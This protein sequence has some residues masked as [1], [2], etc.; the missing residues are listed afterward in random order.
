MSQ[1]P[2]WDPPDPQTRV[3]PT[4]GRRTVRRATSRGQRTRSVPRALGCAV[5]S[6]L[7]PGL[8]Q[9]VQRR[10][11]TAALFGI[12]TVAVLVAAVW[13]VG[14]DKVTLVDWTVDSS[15]PARRSASPVC[16]GP[17]SATR[18]PRT[19][20][21]PRGRHASATAPAPPAT[22]LVVC[23]AVAALLPGTAFALVTVRQD[24]LLDTVFAGSGEVQVAR[25]S[26]LADLGITTTRALRRRRPSPSPLRRRPRPR[27]RPSRRRPS[28]TT[29]PTTP[30][31][32]P[33]ALEHR[34]ARRRRRTQPL[35]PAHRHDDR[36]QRRPPDGRPG[37]RLGAPQPHAAPDAGRAAAATAS[38]T[39]STTWPTRST[40][41]SPSTPSS[42]STRRRPSRAPWPSCSASRSTTT[43]SS[44]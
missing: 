28:P 9:V 39:G 2:S 38:R 44:T 23:V 17:S 15:R 26:P 24:S 18:P 22:L 36:R 32:A 37:Q 13:A 27:R 43:S 5:A 35:G 21:S 41:T 30:P 3:G 6:A 11:R 7:V 25:P 34:A 14:H 4:G 16:S 1:I 31:L 29:V 12:P 20:P 40:P 8:G 42:G 33:R 19:P 10:W